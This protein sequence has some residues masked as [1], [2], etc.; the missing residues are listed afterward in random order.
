M[1]AH[2]EERGEVL[3][4][5]VFEDGATVDCAGRRL[6]ERA[7]FGLPRQVEALGAADEL[8]LEVDLVLQQEL[9]VAGGVEVELGGQQRPR[10]V[11]HPHAG[12]VVAVG[13][14]LARLR[15]DDG[16]VAAVAAH[17]GV[18]AEQEFPYI[19]RLH[20]QQRQAILPQVAPPAPAAPVIVVR[21]ERVADEPPQDGLHRHPLQPAVE[22]GGGGLRIQRGEFR[23]PIRERVFEP[24]P[25]FDGIAIR[26]KQRIGIFVPVHNRRDEDI[27][28]GAARFQLDVLEAQRAD[29]L[30]AVYRGSGGDARFGLFRRDDGLRPFER[31]AFTDEVLD[32]GVKAHGSVAAIF[33]AEHAVG[34]SVGL[35]PAL[36]EGEGGAHE[37]AVRVRADAVQQRGDVPVVAQVVGGTP[38]E[39]KRRR[40]RERERRVAGVG[41]RHLQQFDGVGGRRN[42]RRDFGAQSQARVLADDALPEEAGFE[43]DGV[44]VIRKRLCDLRRAVAGGGPRPD[45]VDVYPE[46]AR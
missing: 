27:R 5:Q 31:A 43:R 36:V 12:D 15:A 22:G 13:L 35:V 33:R 28:L 26:G 6:Q 2:V 39:R 40:G 17:A 16:G 21:Q 8:V 30:V 42:Q 45:A 46:I 9:Q 18:V 29:G 44:R 32:D 10:A 34:D 38:V 7:V 25:E 1:F 23:L 3:D 19:G 41:K 20:E 11:V 24:L 4:E 37:D 14:E